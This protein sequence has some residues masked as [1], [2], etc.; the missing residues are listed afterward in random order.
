MDRNRLYENI[1]RIVESVLNEELGG[2]MNQY[3]PKKAFKM[4]DKINAELTQLKELTGSEYPELLDTSSGSECFFDVVSDVV[5]E[6]GHMKWQERE[7]YTGKIHVEDWNLVREDE[8]EGFWF[9]DYDFKD[10][11]SYLR[12]GIRKATKYYK[13]YN[14]EW[15]DD[16]EKQ[17][18]FIDSL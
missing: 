17:Q 18:R 11:V 16:E 8:E 9:D 3:I 14:M 6:N 1:H 13:E 10:Q 7:A 2:D 5:I 4:V 15:D 12:S